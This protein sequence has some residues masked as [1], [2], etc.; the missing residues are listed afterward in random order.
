MTKKEKGEDHGR[1]KKKTLGQLV[2]KKRKGWQW[3]R[4][5][6]KQMYGGR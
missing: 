6:Q 2:V 4:R 1:V 5:D 3:V